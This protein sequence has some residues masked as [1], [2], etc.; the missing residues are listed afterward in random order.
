MPTILQFTD[1]HVR[2]NLPGHNGHLN[3]LSRHLPAL[4]EE[5]AHRVAEESPDLVL[6]TGDLIDGPH[7]LDRYAGGDA[8]AMYRDAA[9]ADYAYV[10]KWLEALE[11]PWMILPGNH[12][13]PQGFAHVFGDRPRSGTVGDIAVHMFHDWEIEGHQAQRVGEE[14]IRFERIM[15]AA[16]P[17][18]REVHIQHYVVRPV[19]EYGYPLNYRDADELAARL[20][21]APGHRLVL[22][23]H[24]HGGTPLT[25]I[26]Q[27]TFSVCPSFTEPPHPY[28][29]YT[30]D[31]GRDWTMQEK[32]LGWRIGAGKPLIIVDRA[33]ILSDGASGDAVLSMRSGAG[34]LMQGLARLGTVVVATGWDEPDATAQRWSGIQALHDD[35][36]ARLARAGGAADAMAIYL[37]EHSN[38]QRSLPAE[39]IC[40]D[41]D[42]VSGVGTT[43]GVEPMNT[44]FI[45]TDPGRR[46]AAAER[47]AATVEANDGVDV[48]ALIAMTAAALKSRERADSAS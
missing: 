35:F 29:I 45:S 26:G 39:R 13:D 15:D 17:S 40:L 12:D 28:R 23:G 48:A 11:R 31:D 41:T 5:L 24:W 2:V 19:V 38:V 34:A 18:T 47:G 46:H 16:K 33:G 32:S 7:T 14:R 4:M 44:V 6:V 27:A 42:L 1:L 30:T 21:Q 36:F 22:S 8:F 9:I 43:F 20:T 10:R 3:R 37:S 25:V